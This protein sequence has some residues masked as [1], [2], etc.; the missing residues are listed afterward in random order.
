MLRFHLTLATFVIILSRTCIAEGV[1]AEPASLPLIFSEDFE[2]GFSHWQTTDPRNSKPVWKIVEAGPKGNHAFRVTGPSSYKP[3]FRS[4]LSIALLKDIKVS[5]FELK[6]H[7]Q[8]TSPNAGPHRDL[9]F[10]WGYQ[11]PSHFYYAHLASKA[12][13]N[14]CQIFIVNNAPR[15]KITKDTAKG[16]P[17]TNGWHDVKV[18]RRVDSGAIEVYFDDMKRPFMAA[19][20]KTFLWGQVGIGTFDDNGNFDNVVL[21]GKTVTK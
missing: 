13:N 1:V 14:A 12:D 5:D 18:V 15:T 20:D 21:H 8:Q 2:H 7:V 19:R 11:D 10:F 6:V 16:T 4:P 9:C 17:W 3:P